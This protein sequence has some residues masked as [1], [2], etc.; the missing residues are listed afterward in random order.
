MPWKKLSTGSAK[1]GAIDSNELRSIAE[2][3]A[4]NKQNIGFRAADEK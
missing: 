4:E 1:S 3:K 2:A